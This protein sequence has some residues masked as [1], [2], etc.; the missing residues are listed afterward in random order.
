MT[1]KQE[2]E[3]HA[4][5]WQQQLQ[6]PKSRSGITTPLTL[7]LNHPPPPSM[8]YSPT[9]KNITFL[10]EH[11]LRVSPEGADLLLQEGPHDLGVAARVPGIVEGGR[12]KLGDCHQSCMQAAVKW[13]ETTS[14]EGFGLGKICRSRAQGFLGAPLPKRRRRLDEASWAQLLSFGRTSASGAEQL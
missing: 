10:T 11:A 8:K 14:T 3:L 5:T 1:H 6:T 9:Y 4:R 12:R 13:R 2:P 7:I